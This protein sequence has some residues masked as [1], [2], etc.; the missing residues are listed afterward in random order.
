MMEVCVRSVTSPGHAELSPK[1]LADRIMA[2]GAE[3]VVM[4]TDYGQVD[5]PPAAEGMRW[6]IEQMLDCG[7]SPQDVERMTKVNPSRLLGL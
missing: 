3:H 5:S 7:I 4:A 2:V 6:Y 1:E